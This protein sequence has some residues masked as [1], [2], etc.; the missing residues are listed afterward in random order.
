MRVGHGT[1]GRFVVAVVAVVTAVGLLPGGTGSARPPSVN[2]HPQATRAAPW[3]YLHHDPANTKAVDLAGPRAV[4]PTWHALDT[5]AAAT[6]VTVAANGTRY[7]VTMDDGPCHLHAFDPEGNP[8][9]CSD[10]VGPA[11]AAATIVDGNDVVVADDVALRRFGA[12]GSL[13]WSTPI[14][15][16][17]IA[18]PTLGSGELLVMDTAGH[19]T[20]YDPTTGAAVSSTFVVPAATSAVVPITGAAVAAM[21][22]AGMSAAYAPRFLSIFNNIGQV[23][24]NTPAVHPV[25]DRIFIAAAGATAATGM[26][27]GIDYLPAANGQPGSFALACQQPMGPSSE[28]SPAISEDGS[29]VYA[30][31]ASG[32]LYAFETGG[33]CAP[34]WEVQTVTV[35]GRAA[36]SP[37]VGPNGTVVLL[38]AGKAYAVRD[39]GTSATP[40]WTADPTAATGGLLRPGDATARIESTMP[41][42]SNYL[43]AAVTFLSAVPG[44]NPVA[45]YPTDAVLATVDVDTGAFVATA[46]LGDQSASSLSMGRDGSIYVPSK[47]LTR[48]VALIN[49][50]TAP[51]TAAT[52]AGIWTFEPASYRELSI[53]GVAHA[54]DRL[55][56]SDMAAAI[57]QTD[58][59]IENVQLAR[60]RG[61]IST[62]SAI[63]AKSLLRAARGV[64]ELASGHPGLGALPKVAAALLS[65]ADRVLASPG[66]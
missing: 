13:M 60:E 35:A 7:V 40:L 19:T 34:A 4:E 45:T 10:L 59:V 24:T 48:G 21:R 14:S 50:V 3:P 20:A 31:D 22:A 33:A 38:V 27:Y 6:V 30:S 23:V 47:P 17:T 52:R 58:V 65:G 8:L 16:G 56:S 63:V 44:T 28:T 66:K 49:P 54:T 12:D 36:A 9:W 64:M 29:H 2:Q 53:D 18:V 62:S 25:T 51:Y 55:G 11:L 39:D 5:K 42:A 43:Y 57:A 61:E 41:S 32:R 26:L 46:P 37:T 15:T 1:I